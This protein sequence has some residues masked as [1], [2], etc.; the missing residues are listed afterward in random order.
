MPTTTTG[1][2]LTLSQIHGCVTRMRDRLAQSGY[3][4][5]P[6]RTHWFR[7]DHLF[8]LET[9]TPETRARAEELLAAADCPLIVGARRTGRIIVG[10]RRPS[11]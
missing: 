7:W 2:P 3:P 9:P 6:Y 5:G 8:T 4:T 10:F 11:R 1:Q